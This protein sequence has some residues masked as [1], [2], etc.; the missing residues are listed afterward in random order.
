MPIRTVT[1]PADLKDAKEAYLI[2]YS[3]IVNGKLWCPVRITESLLCLT[4]SQ[5]VQCV[6]LCRS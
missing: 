6:G 1:T 5:R 4:E 2:F 3:S